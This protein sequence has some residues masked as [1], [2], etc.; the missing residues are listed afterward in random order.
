MRRFF[1]PAANIAQDQATLRGAEFHHLRH[2]LRLAV[3]APVTLKD[4]LGREHCGIITQ[5]SSS[6]A[7]IALT[8]TRE[9]T[10]TGLSLTLAQGILKGAKMDFVIEKAA[11]LGVQ[12][13]LPFHSTFTVATLP[14]D[15]QAARIARWERIA[16]SAAKQSGSAAPRIEPLQSFT[17]L[18]ETLPS[19]KTAILCYEKE[20]AL[21]LKKLARAYPQLESLCL[22]IG[23]EGGFSSEEIAKARTAGIH[24]VGLGAQILRAE[25]AAIVAS[26]LCQFLWND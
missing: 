15:R 5:L 1:I 8:A 3:G 13:I 26:A 23:P 9:R 25:T 21:S 11:E 20:N 19:E 7:T 22:I 14:A 12:R 18:L 4:D 10:D 17:A 16:H 2:V 6:E 24:I